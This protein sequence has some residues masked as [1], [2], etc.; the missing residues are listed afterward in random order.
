MNISIVQ[1]KG[2]K[3]LNISLDSMIHICLD[4][5]QENYDDS[6]F[7]QLTQKSLSFSNHISKK[8]ANTSSVVC[9]MVSLSFVEKSCNTNTNQIGDVAG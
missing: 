5:K 7:E 3:I 6:I 2:T 8:C 9:H 1:D 4:R